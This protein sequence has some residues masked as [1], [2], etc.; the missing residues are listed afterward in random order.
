MPPLLPVHLLSFLRAAFATI[1]FI[2]TPFSSH[3][4]SF[5]PCRPRCHSFIFIFL[6]RPGCNFICLISN[7]GV[8]LREAF[9]GNCEEIHDRASSVKYLP[10]NTNLL[11]VIRVIVV[12]PTR[13]TFTGVRLPE[14][15]QQRIL[16]LALHAAL[17]ATDAGMSS[18]EVIGPQQSRSYVRGLHYEIVRSTSLLTHL[19]SRNE[20]LFIAVILFLSLTNDN[21]R[22]L[23]R[24]VT[25]EG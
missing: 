12:I 4:H 9:P 25:A 22:E 15:S 24:I 14:V 5:Y 20:T 10:V 21:S 16:A 6:R 13:Q 11:R 17:A 8:A 1:S 19:F 23:C 18:S 2:L 7:E 3:F